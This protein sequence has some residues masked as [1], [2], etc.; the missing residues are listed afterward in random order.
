MQ[1]QAIVS[2]STGLGSL[3]QLERRIEGAIERLRSAHQQQRV[4][5]QEAARLKGLLAEKDQAVERL[6]AELEQVRAER[7]QVRQRIEALL[8]QIEALEP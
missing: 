4:A 7:D 6:G 1:Q 8:E 5:E 3:D 2:E